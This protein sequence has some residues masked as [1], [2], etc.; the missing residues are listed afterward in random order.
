MKTALPH[1]LLISLS[2]LLLCST[3]TQ[4]ADAKGNYAIWGVGNSTCYHYNKARKE[5]DASDDKYKHYLMGYL[6][7]YNTVTEETYSISS[8]KNL[9]TLMAMFDN[10]CELAPLNTFEFV[11]TEV[12]G[13]LYKGRMKKSDAN[14]K[15]VW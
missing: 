14:Q 11:V 1:A 2:S 15:R 9:K 10:K 3:A 8:D 12:V 13:E 6:T 5:G 7:A 4:A